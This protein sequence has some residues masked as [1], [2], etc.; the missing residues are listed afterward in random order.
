MTS[1]G[2]DECPRPESNQRTRFRKPLL[3]PLSY[4]GRRQLCL[5]SRCVDQEPADGLF[6]VACNAGDRNAQSVGR[7]AARR[8]RPRRPDRSLPR[9]GKRR[10]ARARAR[11]CRVLALVVAAAGAAGAAPSALRRRPAASGSI[12]RGR[13]PE[14]VARA[15]ARRGESR[16]R[17]S[18]RPLAWWPRRRRACGT[19]LGAN[20]AARPRRPCGDSLRASPSRARAALDRDA[21]SASPLAAHGRRRR[22]PDGTR[23]PCPRHRVRVEVRRDAGAGVGSRADA[24]RVG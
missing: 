21:R 23:R 3:Y 12:R 4:G 22:R 2:M 8:G 17:R 14:R 6:G 24:N 16:A 7:D 11:A 20:A 5:C 19:Q 1:A 13:G 9:G 10:A 15:L 18:R